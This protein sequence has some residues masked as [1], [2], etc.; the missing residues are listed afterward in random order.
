MRSGRLRPTQTPLSTWAAGLVFVLLLSMGQASAAAPPTVENLRIG[1]AGSTRNN[2]FKVGNWTPVWVQLKGGVDPFSGVIEIEVPDDAGVPTFFRQTVDVPAKGTSRVVSY[3]RIGSR[4]PNLLIRFRD[5]DG[6]L[7]GQT[8][9]GSNAVQ[10]DT[11]LPG[12]S[13]IVTL[14]KPQGVELVPTLPGFSNE[15][16]AT[17]G[18]EL[19]NARIDTG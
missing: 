19:T 1:F 2:L 11:I 16:S 7:V 13:L 5:Q 6:K 4:D 17:G 9:D 15:K 12:E 14:G 18:N 8:L 3:A 10:F